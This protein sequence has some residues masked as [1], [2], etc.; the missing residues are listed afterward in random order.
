MIAVIEEAIELGSGHASMRKRGE[1]VLVEEAN[2][3]GVQTG[4]KLSAR[5]F[6]LE[7]DFVH[8]QRM[9]RMMPLSSTVVHREQPY[10]F[11]R[12]TR[13]LAD[14]PLNIVSRGRTDIRPA[15]RNTPELI[16]LFAH[17][18]DFV[19]LENNTPNIHPRRRVSFCRGEKVEGTTGFSDCE[20]DE[21][22]SAA[23]SRTCS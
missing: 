20:Y 1:G 11:G 6:A 13:F 21:I 22:I 5:D 2:V 12:Q 19:A 10:R 15:A 4:T 3:E 18:Q 16:A 23:I 8:V 17:E 7:K 14:F 9:G